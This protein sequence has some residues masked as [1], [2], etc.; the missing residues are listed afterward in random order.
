MCKFLEFVGTI[1]KDKIPDLI[2]SI[3]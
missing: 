1:C 2:Y 3:Q